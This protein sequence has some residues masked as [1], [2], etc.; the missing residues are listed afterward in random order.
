MS[1][2]SFEASIHARRETRDG[3]FLTLMVNPA[4]LSA[5][6]AM[7]RVGASLMIGWSE[8]VDSSV[9]PLCPPVAE[10]VDAR[11]LGRVER[12]AGSNPVG[13]SKD[14]KPFHTL[15]LS[16]QAALRCQDGKFLDYIGSRDDYPINVGSIIEA[17]R[18]IC[19]VASRSEIIANTPAGDRW[20][21]LERKY[22]E[23]LV[24]QQYSESM[25]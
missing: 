12:R 11:P 25:R 7:L 15:P 20:E 23:Y 5:D 8:I 14:R 19:G 24:T 10:L 21:Q 22:Q 9:Q 6:L 2:G 18:F 17:V 4:D 1:E 16:Q 13:D 3:V